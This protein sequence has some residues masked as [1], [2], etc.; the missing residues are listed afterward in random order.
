VVP[1]EVEVMALE[2]MSM[3][4]RVYGVLV[5]IF[6]GVF[7]HRDDHLVVGR[8]AAREDDIV[9]ILRIAK[10]GYVGSVSISEGWHLAVEEELER[11]PTPWQV[12]VL[13]YMQVNPFPALWILGD[14][15]LEELLSID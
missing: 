8:V 12:D 9:S 15:A 11:G 10:L 1:V 13:I 7:V 4:A 2:R 3:H 5:R 6:L 14:L